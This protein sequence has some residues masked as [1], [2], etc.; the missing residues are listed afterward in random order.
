MITCIEYCRASTSQ[1]EYSV[2]DQD[3]QIREWAKRNKYLIV[4]SYT[5]DGISGHYASKRPAFLQMIQDITTGQ[6]DDSV[7]ALL[8]W[9]SY[10]FARNMVEFL[11][12]KQMIQQHGIQVIA[13]SEPI[14]QD[15]DAQLYIDAI[16]GASGEL[17]LR[18]LSKDSK[19]GIRARVVDRHLHQGHA[20]FGYKN[21][22]KELQINEEQA[23]WVRYCFDE[24]ENGTSYFSICKALNGAG[25]KTVR[26]YDWTV[27]PLKYM[28]S[29]KTYCGKLEANLNG[30]YGL[31]EGSQPAIISEEQFTRVQNI[32]SDISAHHRRYKHSAITYKHWL[33]GLV[34]C[35]VCGHSMSYVQ[36]HDGRR[37]SYRC[38]WRSLSC[39]NGSTR[40]CVLENAVYDELQKIISDPI[41]VAKVKKRIAKPVAS[42]DKQLEK[43]Q[44]RLRLCKEAYLNEI[45]SLDEYRDNKARIE[46]EICKLEESAKHP[47]EQKE[48][49][50]EFQ[51]KA[52][53]LLGVLKSDAPLEDKIRISHALIEKICPDS[54][55]KSIAIYFYA[56]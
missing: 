17:Y 51:N 13:V 46:S 43:L 55:N 45:D 4:K 49:A 15:E 47:E 36:G 54:K 27:P 10:R 12:Y 5:D 26:G 50:S 40:V 8:I 37:P 6:L 2:G 44:K 24:V 19:R 53:D 34:V 52:R 1:Q 18:K 14:V 3:R 23:K 48:D 22:N 39:D 41:Y 31:Y 32:M 28:L 38:N 35:P 20:P 7:S 30:Q 11:T 9:D 42:I 29:N 25:I 56:N 21:V 16:N 33:S